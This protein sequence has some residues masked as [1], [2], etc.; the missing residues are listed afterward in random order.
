VAV[1]VEIVSAIFIIIRSSDIVVIVGKAITVFIDLQSMLIEMKV[2][3]GLH[4]KSV[5]QLSIWTK[6]YRKFP[7][8]RR[9]QR[10]L[11]PL[12]ISVGGLYFVDKG[13]IYTVLEIILRQS[14][15]LLLMYR[16]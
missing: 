1:L 12:R 3:A 14:I 4:E 10:S 6:T 9:I 8:I 11:Q 15:D 5:E 16:H 13:L 7:M 2:G